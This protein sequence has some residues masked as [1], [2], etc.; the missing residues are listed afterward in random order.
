MPDFKGSSRIL[1][2]RND[3]ILTASCTATN[4]G[5]V[6]IYNCSNGSLK[7]IKIDYF[8]ENSTVKSLDQEL[9]SSVLELN[10]KVHIVLLKPKANGRKLPLIV[11]P[12]GGPNSVYSVDYVFYPVILAKMGYAVASSNLYT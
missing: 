5:I 8:D 12:H 11:V 6:N 9:E 3:N 7:N 2:I 1:D 10:S 4:P